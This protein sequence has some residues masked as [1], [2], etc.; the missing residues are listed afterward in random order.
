MGTFTEIFDNNRYNLNTAVNKSNTWFQQQVTLLTAKRIQPLKLIQSEAERNKVKI[1]PGELYLF[2]YDAKHQ[3]KLDYWDM[4]PLVF[5]FAKHPDGFTGLNLH[6]L[7]Y[8]ERIQLLNR[9][10]QY[11][12]NSAM[13]ETTRLKYS[14]GLI[15]SS[16]KFKNAAPCVHRYLNSHLQTPLKKIDAQD[17]ATALMLPVERFVGANKRKVWSESLR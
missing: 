10:M 7:P 3:D 16:S 6:Y 2:A 9:L 8:R 17:W 1:I 11:K 14:W 13:D 15:S 5:P 4:F 12:T